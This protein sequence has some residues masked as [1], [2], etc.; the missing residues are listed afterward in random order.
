MMKVQRDTITKL[1]VPKLYPRNSKCFK[2]L[3][4]AQNLMQS[5]LRNKPAFQQHSLDGLIDKPPIPGSRLN[6]LREKTKQKSVDLS[7]KH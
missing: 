3:L 7:L 6:E 1:R 5:V 4:D 2:S